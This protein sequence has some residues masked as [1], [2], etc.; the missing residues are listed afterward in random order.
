MINSGINIRIKNDFS[1][2]KNFKTFKYITIVYDI[3]IKIP[4]PDWLR[5]YKGFAFVNIGDYTLF[6]SENIEFKYL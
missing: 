5:S 4:F 1:N 2:N 6:F 3:L